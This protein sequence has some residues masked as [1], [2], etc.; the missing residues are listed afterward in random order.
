MQNTIKPITVSNLEEFSAAWNRHDIDALM[1]F[2]SEECIFQTAAGPHAWGSR[3]V[4]T[5]AVRTAFESAWLLVPDAQWL[6]GKHFVHGNL[7]ISEWTFTGTAADGS[8][9]ESDGVD[10]FTFKDGKILLK[11]VFRKNC[12]NL[13]SIK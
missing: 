5:A 1:S 12:P 8:R 2:M 7:G 4:G 6:H 3:H 13:P 9:I 10:I 11:N